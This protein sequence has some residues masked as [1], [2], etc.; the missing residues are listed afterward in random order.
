MRIGILGGNFNPVHY[1][2]LFIADQIQQLLD[3][4]EVQLMPENEPP[5]VDTKTTIS[6]NHRVKMLEIALQNYPKL[7]LNL[8]EIER[9]GKSYTYDTMAKLTAEHPENEYFFIIGGDMLDYLAKWYRIDDLLKLVTFVAVKRD[10]TVLTAPK[11]SVQM[12]ELPLLNISS[13]YIRESLQAK[14]CPNFLL[15]AE[16]L[17]YI[18]QNGLYR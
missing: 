12:L 5:H 8:S 13:S 16:V 4:D 1:A 10:Q 7:T 17:T 2:H 9:G 11:Y 14:R 6:A 15:P 18:D 3:L